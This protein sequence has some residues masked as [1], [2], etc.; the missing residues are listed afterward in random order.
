MSQF[1]RLSTMLDKPLT[2]IDKLRKGSLLQDEADM[3]R[4]RRPGLFGQMQEAAM[5]SISQRS[6]ELPYEKRRALG[7]LLGIPT[8]A[9]LAPDFVATMQASYAG[10]D[11][12]PPTPHSGAKLNLVHESTM[13]K[14]E[15]G[16]G[17]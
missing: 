5:T 2:A 13:D 16:D 15:Q 14:M 8:D 7:V 17:D 12:A 1:L 4:A 3:L 9:S 6:S 10:R 11:E